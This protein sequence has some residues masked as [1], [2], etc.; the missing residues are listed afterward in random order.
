MERRS[1]LK[2]SLA[3]G[4]TAGASLL[5]LEDD[6][7]PNNSSNNQKN[8]KIEK[9][10]LAMLSMQMKQKSYPLMMSA[11]YLSNADIWKKNRLP[12]LSFGS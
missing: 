7:F 4:T 3:Y 9:V 1:F 8:Q 11:L 5:C 12:A 2:K 10:K 6:V